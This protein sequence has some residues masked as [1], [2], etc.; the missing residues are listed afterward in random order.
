MGI[1][2]TASSTRNRCCGTHP[3]D[4][5]ETF[6]FPV[7][8]ARVCDATRAEHYYDHRRQLMLV[9]QEGLTR[10]YNRFHDPARNRRGHRP[11]A[12]VARRDGPR[13]RCGIWVGRTS[14]SA[15]ASPRTRSRASASQSAGRARR[16]VLDRLLR[17]NHER[18]AEEVAQGLHD[19]RARAGESPQAGRGRKPKVSSGEPDLFGVGE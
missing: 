18:Y 15:T 13:R 2:N 9:A 11:A 17:L 5:F 10:T 7:N 12:R 1:G 6:P 16:E 14:T 19:K 4:C 3:S 8:T